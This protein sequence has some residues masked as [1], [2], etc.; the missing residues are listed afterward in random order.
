[1][2]VSSVKGKESLVKSFPCF[3]TR[4]IG[5]LTNAVVPGQGWLRTRREEGNISK[6]RAGA[7]KNQARSE[8]KNRM[9]QHAYRQ[10]GFHTGMQRQGLSG[11]LL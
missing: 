5:V 3:P 4:F 1:M 8:H 10:R 11:S 2:P 7:C 9:R 6:E